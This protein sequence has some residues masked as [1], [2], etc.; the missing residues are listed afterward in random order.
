MQK[1]TRRRIAVS[2][3]RLKSGE[4]LKNQ[5]LEIADGKIVSANPLTGELPNVEWHD[6]EV[7]EDNLP[8]MILY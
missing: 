6:V 5:I 8:D 1:S 3:L 2:R 7:D 4:I